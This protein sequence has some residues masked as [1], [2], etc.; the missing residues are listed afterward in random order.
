MSYKEQ[1][2]IGWLI[3]PGSHP[4]ESFHNPGLKG[5]KMSCKVIWDLWHFL[6]PC[7]G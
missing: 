3:H 5:P 6:E 7:Q 2:D 1:L 4:V